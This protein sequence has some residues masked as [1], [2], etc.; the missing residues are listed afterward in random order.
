MRLIP[1]LAHSCIDFAFGQTYETRDEPAVS[2]HHYRAPT[3]PVRHGARV[4]LQIIG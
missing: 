1:A 3:F 4:D 2:L